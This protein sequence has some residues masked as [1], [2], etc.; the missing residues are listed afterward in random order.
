MP[1]DQAIQNA[2]Q[3]LGHEVQAAATASNPGRTPEQRA[4]H[5]RR[6]QAA[7]QVADAV[8][9]EAPQQTHQQAQGQNSTQASSSTDGQ[10]GQ[11]NVRPSYRGQEKRLETFQ[12]ARTVARN[13][14]GRFGSPRDPPANE[15]PKAPPMADLK[16]LPARTYGDETT[17]KGGIKGLDAIPKDW[18]KLPANVSLG[19]EVSWVQS[20]RLAVVKELPSGGVR[21]DLAKAYAPAPSMAALSWLETSIR[22]YAKF[23]EVAAKQASSGDDEAEFIRRERMAIG[24]IRSILA[25]MMV[26]KRG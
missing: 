1:D 3:Q 23:I 8:S 17:P 9:S 19:V 4:I 10:T 14:D 24:E 15:P 7:S 13:A 2:G 20:N 21:V 25:E 5:E 26:D 11:G 18:P 6:A 22:S 12:S 16:P